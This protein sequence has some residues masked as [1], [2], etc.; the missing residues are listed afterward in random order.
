MG[1]DVNA[2]TEGHYD[3]EKPHRPVF[4]L[5]DQT[6]LDNALQELEVL[7]ELEGLDEEHAMAN[8]MQNKVVELLKSAGGKSHIARTIHTRELE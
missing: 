3:E 7:E 4:F 5:H 6:P 2:L 8:K 1:A